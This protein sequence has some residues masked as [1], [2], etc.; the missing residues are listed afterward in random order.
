MAVL[1]WTVESAEDVVGDRTL[2]D[3]TGNLF[4]PVHVE[5]FHYLGFSEVGDPDTE[6]LER[7]LGT[8]YKVGDVSNYIVFDLRKSEVCQ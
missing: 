6:N 1:G 5:P 2:E 4:Q 8:A 7:A 3:D